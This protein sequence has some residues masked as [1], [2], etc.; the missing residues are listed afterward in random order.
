MVTLSD[1]CTFLLPQTWQS[2]TTSIRYRR[3]PAIRYLSELELVPIQEEEKYDSRNKCIGDD[4]K[5]AAHKSLNCIKTKKNM[6]KNDFQYGGWNSYTL[7]CGTIT[8]LILSGD[9]TLQCGMWLWNRDSE[10]T[11]WQHLAM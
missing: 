2:L 7:Q 9:F 8:T 5:A 6:A 3:V 4:T 10:F 1:C 11:K